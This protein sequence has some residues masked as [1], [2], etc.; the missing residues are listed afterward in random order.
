MS[1][2]FYIEGRRVTK[3]GG[4]YKIKVKPSAYYREAWFYTNCGSIDVC[5]YKPNFG[6]E[7]VN[8][9]L[10]TLRRIVKVLEKKP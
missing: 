1:N 5:I 6:T 10:R 2:D 3:H 9:P 4:P 7:H 8:I